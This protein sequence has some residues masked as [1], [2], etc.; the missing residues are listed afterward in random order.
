MHLTLCPQNFSFYCEDKHEK[1]TIKLCCANYAAHNNFRRLEPSNKIEKN[2]KSQLRSSSSKK[3]TMFFLH[4]NFSHL[5]VATGH[6]KYNS[7]SVPRRSIDSSLVFA[8]VATP[9]ASSIECNDYLPTF[10]FTQNI[11]FM[12]PIIFC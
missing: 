5:N 11:I 12:L 4:K 9:G 2:N 1:F 10:Q 6:K 7:A 8:H 3:N